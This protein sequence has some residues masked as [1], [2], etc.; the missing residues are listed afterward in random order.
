MRTK[1]S[2]PGFV[3]DSSS[4]LC[5][6]L[7]FGHE[8]Q[9]VVSKIG[10]NLALL[11]LLLMFELNEGTQEIGGPE[12]MFL[13][14]R[15]NLVKEKLMLISIKLKKIIQ[16]SL[17]TAFWSQ[18]F[19][20]FVFSLEH[21]SPEITKGDK[22]DGQAGWSACNKSKVFHHEKNIPFFQ[23]EHSIKLFLN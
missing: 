23:E 13:S 5:H 20:G 21:T 6:G 4:W 19:W 11:W 22:I 17:L 1:S 2:V 15:L 12:R 9:K 8:S 7:G 10:M 3:M 16:W 14:V 18:F